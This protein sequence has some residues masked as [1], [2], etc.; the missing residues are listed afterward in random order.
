MRIAAAVLAVVALALPMLARG[1]AA[2]TGQA[3]AAALNKR[4]PDA[5]MRLVDAEAVTRLVTGNL[6]L[7]G[8]ERDGVAVGVPMGLR[9]NLDI[10]MRSIE[11]AK[12]TAKFLRAGL[13]GARPYALVRYDLG[14]QG[15]EY[16]EY[17][18]TA[19]GKIEDW[20]LHGAAML[21]S[22][23]AALGIATLLKSDSPMSGVLGS[24]VSAAD[25]R[26]FTELRERLRAQ[27]FAGAYRVLETFPESLRKT[28]QWA[29]M[30]V[31]FGGRVDDA[32]YRAALRYVAQ[33]FGSD[34]DL[35]FMLIDH[36]V[37]EG[38]PDRAL[39]SVAALE[40]AIGGEDAATANLRGSI[41]T[42]MKRFAEAEKACRRGI[43]LEAD[44]K[45][46][47]WC[48]V[49]V[50]TSTRNGRLAIEGLEAYERAFN[51]RFD[52]ARLATLEHYRE[53]AR[54]PEFAAWARSRQ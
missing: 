1:D 34:T 30:R 20:Y 51:V 19:S 3:I 2:A 7:E 46:A 15:T 29:M 11:S 21:Y 53:I 22:T 24:R 31:T 47:Y 26:P 8:P 28:R 23:S 16:V 54:T 38:Q 27:D 4:D 18:V 43:S 42:G 52:P 12:G 25:L 35:Q 9:A 48:L 5:L 50:G 6:V 45:P 36:Y 44:H 33:N 17:Y 10:G 39:A 14:D 37:Y 40:R 13:R 49:T 41:L 32:T